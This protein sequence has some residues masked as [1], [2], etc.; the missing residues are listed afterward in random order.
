MNRIN[1]SLRG[2]SCPRVPNSCDW[3]QSGRGSAPFTLFGALVGGPKENDDYKD[4]RGDYIANEVATDYN[5]GFQSLV[6]AVKCKFASK[7]NVNLL[8][9]TS[10]V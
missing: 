7:C 10:S 4:D 8:G 1:R 5:A 3:G 9:G 6:A 2:S